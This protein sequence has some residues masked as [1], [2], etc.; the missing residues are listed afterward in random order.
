MACVCVSS[1]RLRSVVEEMVGG[2]LTAR[3]VRLKAVLAVNAPSLT[4]RVT[5]AEPLW[6]VAGR[7]TM[8]RAL[9]IPPKMMRLIGM[10]IGLLEV[11]ERVRFVA[12]VSVSEMVNDIAGV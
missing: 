8:V 12:A 6:F 9:P 3:T 5:L 2:S 11:A 7:S 4:G 1:L 10:R